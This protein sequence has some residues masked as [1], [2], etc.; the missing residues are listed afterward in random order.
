M[1]LAPEFTVSGLSVERRKVTQGVPTR[2]ASSWTPPES[3]TIAVAPDRRHRKSVYPTGG[4][5]RTASGRARPNSSSFLPVRGWSGRSRGTPVAAAMPARTRRTCSRGWRVSTFSG[6][7]IVTTRYPPRRTPKRARTSACPVLD[8]ARWTESATVLPTT[9]TD[10]AAMPSP[11]RMSRCRCETANRYVAMWSI[12][13]RLVSSG[14]R[15]S[16]ERRPASTWAMGIWAWL[17]A[18]AH[19]NAVFVSPCTTTT[20]GV[21]FSRSS[22]IRARI[23]AVCAESEPD[24]TPRLCVGAGTASS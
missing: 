9:W 23:F 17:A 18:R 24:P 6:R 22:P 14:M 3:V 7:C 12:R 10:L 2:E 11:S 21:S 16:Y 5:G 1:T 19:A 13:V 4:M 20:R 8:K 15:R